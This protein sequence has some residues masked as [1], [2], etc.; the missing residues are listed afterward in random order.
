MFPSILVSRAWILILKFAVLVC[1]VYWR[2]LEDSITEKSSRAANP[3]VQIQA[4]RSDIPEYH[5]TH[6][7]ESF[8]EASGTYYVHGGTL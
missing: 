5:S 8:A 7:S 3:P 6:P 4:A 1:S 2:F